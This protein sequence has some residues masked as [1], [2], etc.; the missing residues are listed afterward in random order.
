M[1]AALAAAMDGG[2]FLQPPRVFFRA[3]VLLFF[4]GNNIPF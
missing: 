4:L 3:R 2:S 1:D